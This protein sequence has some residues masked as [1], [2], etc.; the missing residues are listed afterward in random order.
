MA[1]VS[2]TSSLG[3]TSLRGFGGMASGINR[4]EIIEKMTLGTTTKIANKKKDMQKLQWKQEAYRNISDQILDISDNYASYASG[5]N[6]K[7]PMAFAKSIV[8]IHGRDTATQFV[9][10]SGTSSMIENVALT[11]VK[12][13]ATSTVRQSNQ[14]ISNVGLKT[15]LKDLDQKFS[16]SNLEGGRLTFGIPN[17]Q[18]GYDKTV[19]FS[20]PTAYME[21]GEEKRLNYV[22]KTPEEAEVL[23]NH[24]N[25]ALEEQNLNFGEG[26]DGFKFEYDKDT[27]QIKLTGDTGG[28]KIALDRTTPSVLEGLGYDRKADER[29]IDINSFS[30]SISGKKFTETCQY[31]RSALDLMV[32]EKLTFNYD[33][34][35]KEIEL[36]TKEEAEELRNLKKAD[37]TTPADMSEKMQKLADNIQKRLDKAFGEGMVTAKIGDG[38]GNGDSLTFDTKKDSSTISVTSNNYTLLTNMGLEYGASNKINLNGTLAQNKDALNLTDDELKGFV[39][40]GK[41]SL[42]INGVTIDGLTE[43]STIKDILSKINSSD[44]GV[45]ATY[46]ESTGQFMLVA[47]ETGAARK[48]DVEAG[49]GKGGSALAQK[50]FMATNPDGTEDTSKTID[51]KDAIIEVSYGNGIKVDMERASN[52][53]DLEGLNITV[54]GVFGGEWAETTDTTAAEAAIQN[55]DLNYKKVDGKYMKWN[56]NTSE[57]VTFSAKADVDGTVEKV[58]KFFE[59]FNKLATDINNEVRT[60]PD[61]SYEPLTDEQKDEMDET[62]IENWEKKAKQGML[63][64]DSVMRDLNLD[65]QGIFTKMMQNGAS[66]EDLKEIGITY[67]EDWGD[68]GVLV[69]DEATFRTAMEKNPEKVSNIFAGGGN[70]KKGL[71]S[72]VEDTFTPYATKY[73]SKNPG[74]NGGS[75]GRLIEVAG[76][77]KKPT[78]LMNNEIYK[79]LKEM[80]DAIAVLQDRLKVEQDRYIS[81]FTTMESLINKMNTQSSYLSQITG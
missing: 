80:E 68:G 13:L 72:T 59:D 79:Q 32:G 14:H 77:S 34:S 65:I 40:N 2:S 9:R 16:F 38:K 60:R 67:S 52:T 31:E 49:E 1:S 37:G 56:A 6:L 74:P 76:S 8:S 15:D 21:N 10:A 29:T 46:V 25:K 54:S 70:V 43:K 53:F 50:L 81:Q 20:F 47:S 26:K 41:L 51:G 78:T 73:A 62:S 64:G 42:K 22:P 23:V 3:N 19:T 55:G 28:Y 17:D 69:F 48:I 18:G 61:S 5:S 39:N 11:G 7:D 63:Y 12:Q 44:A 4:D 75:Y 57:T 66:Y 45:K 35:K 58:K 27:D 24:L 36:V 30:N 71:I 33:G